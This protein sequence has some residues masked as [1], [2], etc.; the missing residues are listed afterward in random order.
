LKPGCLHRSDEQPHRVGKG[1]SEFG[2]NR[3]D[4]MGKLGGLG[5]RLGTG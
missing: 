5:R 2:V 4:R 1:G 3:K